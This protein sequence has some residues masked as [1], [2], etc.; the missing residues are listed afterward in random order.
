MK[1]RHLELLAAI[2]K[3]REIKLSRLVETTGASET[4]IRRNIR[5]LENA[6]RVIRT[7][8]SVRMAPS[9]SLVEQIFSNRAQQ[10]HLQKQAIAKEAAALVQPGMMVAIDAGSTAWYVARL[11]KTKAPLTVITSAIA[12]LEELG[13]IPGITFFLVGGRYL[14]ENLSFM[15]ADTVDKFQQIH[16]D[17]A[18]VG[19]EALN[20][21]RGAFGA[22]RAGAN[23]GAVIAGCA[24]RRIL[25][26]DS[27][28]IEASMPFLIV[29]P[30]QIDVVITDDGVDAK[31]R[32]QLTQE[33]YKM[34]Y[35]AN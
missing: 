34:I 29:Q 27:S 26:G 22:S 6:G 15:S 2:E 12:P 20:C 33:P 23:V 21:G 7:F 16:A 9:Q 14:P 13:N 32:Q 4:T 24:N 8:G 5:E 1:S 19:F 35:A 10:M 31:I 11:L 18:F 28:K 3:H 17:I 30:D 25:V